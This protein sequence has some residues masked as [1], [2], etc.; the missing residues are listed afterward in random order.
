MKEEAANAADLS[1]G[2]DLSPEKVDRTTAVDSTTVD[3][4]MVDLTMVDLTMAAEDA[5]AHS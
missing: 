2:P 5:N 3:L 4:T 1:G